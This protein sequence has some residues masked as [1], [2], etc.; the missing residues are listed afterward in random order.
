MSRKHDLFML[1]I[2][3]SE[4]P[5]CPACRSP[6]DAAT[7]PPCPPVLD[8]IAMRLAY[9]GH[10]PHSIAHIMLTW[11]ETAADRAI[12]WADREDARAAVEAAEACHDLAH[13]THY[14]R[15]DDD[16]RSSKR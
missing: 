5:Q 4:T 2:V 13:G 16:E 8:D 3:P 1:T 15:V 7:L 12:V 10:D 9:Q 6:D 11:A 14:H